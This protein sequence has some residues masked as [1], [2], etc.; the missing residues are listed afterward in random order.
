MNINVGQ[1]L[2]T[3]FC[4][5]KPP[6]YLERFNEFIVVLV[7]GIQQKELKAV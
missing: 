7:A 3:V 1:L 4:N 2:T 5:K 6:L